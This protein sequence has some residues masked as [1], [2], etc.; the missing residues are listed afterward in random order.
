ME[1]TFQLLLRLPPALRCHAAPPFLCQPNGPNRVFSRA[2]P[3]LQSQPPKP[4][5]RRPQQAESTS[6][7]PF[8]TPRPPPRPRTGPVSPVTTPDNFLRRFYESRDSRLLLY[9]APKHTS[10]YF[11]SY[12]LGAILL[13]GA[14]LQV[15]NFRAPPAAFE[16]NAAETR[17]PSRWVHITNWAGAGLLSGFATAFFLAPWKL[18]KTVTLVKQAGASGG[19]GAEMLFEL[20]HP[21][22][23]LQRLPLVRNTGGGSISADVHKVLIDRNVA[24]SER[25]SYHSV[26]ASAAQAWTAAY[27]TP[28][29]R[30]PRSLL[31]RLRSANASLVNAWPALKTDVGRMFLREGM[32]YVRIPEHGNWK[33]DLNG[34]EVLEHGKVLER[35]C[36][37]D[38]QAV[39]RS[40]GAW[41]KG[42]FTSNA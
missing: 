27:F 16:A 28:A 37:V 8:Q 20:K 19:R 34:C 18:I 35:L 21:F 24:A 3:R 41:F 22:P 31:A 42:K 36:I 5:V 12:I 25:L 39:D 15:W 29:P 14:V 4:T 17:R 1:T 33:M 32:A 2:I 23:P 10:F 6:K 40:F 38:A 11:N 7:A 9:K 26:P 13:T 30:E